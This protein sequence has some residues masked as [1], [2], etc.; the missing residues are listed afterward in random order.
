MFMTVPLLAR[1]EIGAPNQALA[2]DDPTGDR[3]RSLLAVLE[4]SCAAP[5]NVR[6]PGEAQSPDHGA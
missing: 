1:L 5:L 2:A 6:A 3:M 4:E